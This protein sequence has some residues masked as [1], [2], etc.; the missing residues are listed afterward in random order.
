MGLLALKISFNQSYYELL[1]IQVILFC[2]LIFRLSVSIILYLKLIFY[3][4]FFR[5]WQMVEHDIK[6]DFYA[7]KIIILA[8]A[9][10][11]TLL[12]YRK[13]CKTCIEPSCGWSKIREQYF[14]ILVD[15]NATTSINIVHMNKS[16]F[17]NLCSI[18]R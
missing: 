13:R 3:F 9:Y 6:D 2:Q 16:S 8:V 1:L 11:I 12:L 4:V 7:A 5:N 10:A 15:G 18:M 17:F 14:S